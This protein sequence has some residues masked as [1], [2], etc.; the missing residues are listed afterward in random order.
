MNRWPGAHAAAGPGHHPHHPPVHGRPHTR[1]RSGVHP[2]AC[3]SCAQRQQ[4]SAGALSGAARR[5]EGHRGPSAAGR[6]VPRRVGREA[7]RTTAT[8]EGSGSVPD[9]PKARMAATMQHYVDHF[10]AVPVVV[11]VCLV[12]HRRP[13]PTEGGSV[14]PACQNLLLAARAMGYGGALTMWHL[15]VE[16]ATARPARHP[17]RRGAVGLHH[18][19]PSRRAARPGAP[20]TAHRGGVRRRVGCHGTVGGRTPWVPVSDDPYRTLGVAPEAGLAGTGRSAA[21]AGD[22]ASPRPRWH[23]HGHASGERSLRR[24]RP[25][26]VDQGRRARRSGAPALLA[27]G[28]LRSGACAGSSTTRPRSPST[29]SRWRRTRRSSWSPRGWVRCWSTIPPYVLETFLRDPAPCWCRLD[30]VPDAGATTVSLTVAGIDGDAT[31]DPEAV[32]DEWIANLN[33]LDAP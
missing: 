20:P 17:S 28:R 3:E 7:P 29:C 15:M 26:T 25:P 13:T 19:R 33:R 21:P 22:D 31:P 14:Y 16:T 1:G 5:A 6:V 12:R 9:S 8:N 11:L 2:L 30:L 32:R 24:G 18:P 23:R 27:R 4:P 10:E